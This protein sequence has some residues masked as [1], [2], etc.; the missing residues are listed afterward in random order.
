M[1]IVFQDPVGS[2]NRRKMV[3]QIIGLPLLV[4]EHASRSERRKQ[5][6]ELLGLVGLHRS[7]AHRYPRELSGGECQRV[8]I[9]RAIALRPSFVVLDEAVS[10][11]D[12]SVQAQILNLLRDLQ[13]ELGLTYLFVSH[14]LAVV[15]YMAPTVAVMQ[16]GKIVEQGDRETIFSRPTHPYTRSLL[17]ALTTSGRAHVAGNGAD[18][19]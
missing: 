4:H 12:V 15:R 19:A 13:Q 3:E 7:L 5:V 2:L 11:V 1:Q 8:S 18:Q 17:R 9:A 6:Q 16:N 10:S 14:D